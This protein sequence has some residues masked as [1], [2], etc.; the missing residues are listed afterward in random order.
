[1]VWI[2]PSTLDRFYIYI[3]NTNHIL[4]LY[5]YFFL[6]KEFFLEVMNTNAKDTRGVIIA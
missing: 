2:N 4:S 1:M 5:Y 3:Y 6:K